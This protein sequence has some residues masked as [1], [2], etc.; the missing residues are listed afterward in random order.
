MEDVV[1]LP[2]LALFTYSL[3]LFPVGLFLPN[4]GCC[5]ICPDE[6]VEFYRC[7]KFVNTNPQEPPELYDNI[8]HTHGFSRV[9]SRLSDIGAYRVCKTYRENG[10]CGEWGYNIRLRIPP[11][12][13]LGGGQGE[14]SAEE[15]ITDFEQAESF[16]RGE[17][18]L[19]AGFN[20]NI[21]GTFYSKDSTQWQISVNTPTPFCGMGLCTSNHS[22]IENNGVVFGLIDAG[23]IPL[24]A[25]VQYPEEV[26]SYGEVNS[27]EEVTNTCVG[28]SGKP[29]PL[30][31]RLL[32]SFCNYTNSFRTCESRLAA[33]SS[34]VCQSGNQPEKPPS[35]GCTGFPGGRSLTVPLSA[36]FSGDLLWAIEHGPSAESRQFRLN[37]YEEPATV[38]LGGDD[39]VP[40]KTGACFPTQNLVTV[41]YN[42][43]K[44]APLEVEF[45]V[46]ETELGNS[47]GKSS[48]CTVPGG[49]YIASGGL[50]NCNWLNYSI[51]VTTVGPGNFGCTCRSDFLEATYVRVKWCEPFSEGWALFGYPFA[52]PFPHEGGPGP[53]GTVVFGRELTT[54]ACARP[55]QTVGVVTNFEPLEESQ[56]TSSPSEVFLPPEG[57]VVSVQKC[58]PPALGSVSSSPSQ[59]DYAS[60]LVSDGSRWGVSAGRSTYIR[61][62]GRQSSVLSVRWFTFSPS[63]GS[64]TNWSLSSSPRCFFG[65]V[66]GLSSEWS[67]VSDVDWIVASRVLEGPQANLLKV[68]IKSPSLNAEGCFSVSAPGA[69]TLTFCLRRLS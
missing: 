33:R 68:V 35:A 34:A 43:G 63:S 16:L 11:A 3:F 12:S 38:T 22:F 9:V 50:A 48:G 5:D 14:S 47:S 20:V 1:C 25:T 41:P 6:D 24:S 65:Q 60:V 15:V 31:M 52:Y 59:S 17:Q 19:T 64:T 66:E 32:G 53:A 67:V 39:D 8:T 27:R 2:L 40:W 18:P 30:T 46:E 26:E 23:V 62:A 49:T 57:G 37:Q 4:C 10:S 13:W 7:I 61:Q 56:Y 58:C 44:C 69:T 45:E 21:S 51:S 28:V 36:F 42:K 54:S 55:R 29:E